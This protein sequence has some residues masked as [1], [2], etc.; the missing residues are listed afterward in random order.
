MGLWLQTPA[1]KRE[2][3]LRYRVVEGGLLAFDHEG[4]RCKSVVVSCNGIIAMP[5]QEWVTLFGHAATA[6]IRL[7]L[8]RHRRH[9]AV[10]R[11]PR[12]EPSR[13]QRDDPDHQPVL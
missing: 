2:Q 13:R 1:V 11:Q 8:A 3:P 10:G 4:L 6:Q 5:A 7:A 12:H 9:F